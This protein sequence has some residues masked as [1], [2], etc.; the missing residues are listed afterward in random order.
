MWSEL[1]PG[2]KAQRLHRDDKN[3]HVDHVNQQ[4]TGYQVGSDVM[5]AFMIPGIRTTRENG[6]TLAI[7]GS[8]LWDNDTAPKVEEAIFAEM[9]V[10]EC[11]VMLGSVFHGGGTNT[12][13]DV[14]RI[15]HG[16]FFRKG[17]YRQEENAYLANRAEDVLPWSSEAQKLLGYHLSTPNIGYLDFVPPVDY[18]RSGDVKPDRLRDLA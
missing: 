5:L 7:P 16:L 3:Y 11:F 8:H 18:L 14:R 12:T 6:A 4:A 1:G 13:Q 2:G 10:G 9:E 17:Y 15:L